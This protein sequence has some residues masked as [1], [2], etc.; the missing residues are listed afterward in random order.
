MIHHQHG[1]RKQ[2]LIGSPCL[3]PGTAHGARSPPDRATIP[4]FRRRVLR[5]PQAPGPWAGLPP[6]PPSHHTSAGPGPRLQPPFAPPCT[7]RRDSPLP[8]LSTAIYSP[9]PPPRA[10]ADPIRPPCLRPPPSSSGPRRPAACRAATD[11]RPR[12]SRAAVARAR[13][14]RGVRRETSPDAD[15]AP[16]PPIRFTS[17]AVY[18]TERE[19][20]SRCFGFH[21]SSESF[22]DAPPPPSPPPP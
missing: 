17:L 2:R 19:S 22:A 14:A 20:V 6:G 5:I 3:C 10:R 9:G 21:A 15:A 12:E 18:N 7:R 4:A 11:C 8:R 16:P 1:Y 13:P